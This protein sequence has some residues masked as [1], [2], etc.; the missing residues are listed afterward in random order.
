[1]MV[2][3]LGE[4]IKAKRKEKNM[5]LKDLAGNR[6]TPG[7]ISLVESGK[8]NP[9]IDLLE[10]LADR[11]NTD[12]EY[13]LESEEKQATRICEFYINIAESSET[14]DN[15]NEAREAIEKGMYYADKYNLTFFR[16]ILEMINANMKYAAGDYEEAQQ[17]CL[18]ANSI[19]LRNDNIEYTVKSFILLGHIAFNIGYINTALNY[20]MQGDSI[21]KENNYVGEFLLAKVYYN[22]SL[23]YTKMNEMQLATDYAILVKERLLELNNK[24][25][26]AEKLMLLSI[27]LS[28]K[29]K[30]IDALIYS[31]EAKKIYTELSD[32]YEMADIETNLGVIFAKG[33]NIDE[34]CLHYENAIK[35]KKQVA[36]NTLADTILKMCNSCIEIND[37][38][39]AL[40]LV[41]KA[42]S[43]IN[44]EQHLYK[45]KCY[46]L[47]FN[48]FNKKG[49]KKHAEEILLNAIAYL[50]K[51][52]YKKQLGNFYSI[53]G[54]FY[55][56]IDE[57]ELALVYISKGI[58]LYKE[59]GIILGD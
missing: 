35:L 16:G 32:I 14:S 13:F 58:D 38:D 27:S 42:Q 51:F 30:I 59:L 12:V 52:N 50:E 23:C 34:S 54:K 1:M 37:Y 5:T 25:K 21:L 43:L 9:S 8:S 33:N 6:I 31:K 3:T 56:E 55:I 26:Y 40:E 2:F 20:F 53:L 15:I 19:F 4:K 44:E 11:L 41:N 57:K 29:N 17:L 22:I 46:E 39:K 36:D 10:Y 49:E 18:S 45:A 24:K 28:E 48:I 47:L 7:Q